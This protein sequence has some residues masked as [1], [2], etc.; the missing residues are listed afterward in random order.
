ML[1]AI[2]VEHTAAAVGEW[3]FEERLAASINVVLAEVFEVIFKFTERVVASFNY[4]F[5]LLKGDLVHFCTVEI[6][7]EADTV[8][9]LAVATSVEGNASAE[10][11][12]EALR[13]AFYGCCVVVAVRPSNEVFSFFEVGEDLLVDDVAARAREILRLVGDRFKASRDVA[14]CFNEVEIN[15]GTKRKRLAKELLEVAFADVARGAETNDTVVETFDSFVEL[16]PSVVGSVHLRAGGLR[17]VPAE[18]VLVFFRL[19][20]GTAVNPFYISI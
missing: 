7:A 14:P 2:G 20:C 5:A 17:V 18:H 15:K 8:F 1:N 10:T 3:E 4:V 16:S 19:C 6:V 11:F 9:A 12:D 13:D